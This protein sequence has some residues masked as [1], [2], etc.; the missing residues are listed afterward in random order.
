MASF[1][2]KDL[3]ILKKR[4]EVKV[5]RFSSIL[6][7]YAIWKG[8]LWCNLTF[9]WFGSLH[10]FFAVLFSKLLG[11]KSIV[12]A[13]GY[14]VVYLPEIKYGLFLFW[15][16]RWCPLMVF[17]Y[18]DLILTVSQ[19]TTRETL[20]NAKVD[21]RKIRLLHH[22]FKPNIH[23]SQPDQNKEPIVLSV[24]GISRATLARKGL[25][26]FVKSSRF[27]P[28]VEFVLVGKWVDDS[29]NYLRSI[30]SSN[31]RFSGAI[32]ELSLLTLMGKSKVYVQVSQHEGFGCSLA[33][34]M[35]CECIPVVTNV[36]AIPEVVGDCGFFLTDETPQMLANLIKRALNSDSSLGKKARERIKR[37]FPLKKREEVLLQIIENLQS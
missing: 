13:G 10:S 34:A 2:K 26:L 24:G 1:I 5:V 32:D 33:E 16:K 35:L 19:N 7:A 8:T 28:E 29:V 21:A 37:L 4:H 27:L 11:K 30:A 3:E 23:N 36:A 6:D 31:M 25:E 12:V 22:G 14:D 9:C 20:R 18:A 17:R 15:W